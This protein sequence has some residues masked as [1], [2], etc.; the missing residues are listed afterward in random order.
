MFSIRL[1]PGAI[2]SQAFLCGGQAGRGLEND[3]PAEA[4][5][6]NSFSLNPNE[7]K[8]WGWASLNSPLLFNIGADTLDHGGSRA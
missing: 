3:D 4:D 8:S 5:D 7:Y 2:S 6:P 1:A